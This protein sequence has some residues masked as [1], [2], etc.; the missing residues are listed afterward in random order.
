MKIIVDLKWFFRAYWKKYALAVS[1]FL[2]IGVADMMIPLLT[3]R[4]IDDVVAQ[5]MTQERLLGYGGIILAIAVL[6]YICRFLWRVTLFSASYKLAEILRQRIYRHMTFMAPGFF[7]IHRTGDLMARATNDITAVEMTA[8]EGVLSATDGI[9]TSVF[10]LSVMVLVIDWRLT[11]IA[12]LPFPV[13]AWFFRTIGTRLHQSF[14][15]AQEEFSNLNDRVQESIAG[16]RMIKSFG[17]E[18]FED[19]DFLKI[20]DRAAEANMEVAKT[21]SLYDPAIFLTVGTSFFSCVGY[22]GWLVH[23]QE[24]TLGQLTSFTM[25]LGYLIW[26]MF[27]YGWLMNILERGSAAWARISDL[28]ETRSPVSDQ[29]ELT[30]ITRPDIE[31]DIQS[32]RYSDTSEPVLGRIQFAIQAGETI[33]VVGHTGAGKTT[34]I[35]LL[36]RQYDSSNAMVNISGVPVEQYRLTAL[37]DLMSV[38]PQ[39]PFLFTATIE[40]NIAMG[41]PEASLEQVREVARLASVDSDILAFPE[42]Y[43]TLVGERGVTLSGGQKQRLS[44]ARAL[45][46]DAPILILDDALSAVDVNTEKKIL[47][48]LK[49]ARTDK[50]TLIICHR[51]TAIEDADQILVLN[52][53]EQEE[54]GTHVQL[55][56]TA[57]WYQRMFEYQQLEQTVESGK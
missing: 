17:R 16:I 51:L 7:Q 8:G 13:M 42:G 6:I 24:L 39:D 3:G 56:R 26:P 22:G 4:L 27:A 37:R 36:M 10:V 1:L 40:E 35:H 19:A 55:I 28:L 45:L 14:K 20:A 12:L 44:I 41:R 9:I 49:R 43:N 47:S 29:G 38:V 48:H 5:S 21:D 30:E 23:Q 54:I 32:F 46:T 34:L 18:S 31:F 25:Y 52:H 2:I 15:Q 50:T 53:G 11:L 33:G 57:G